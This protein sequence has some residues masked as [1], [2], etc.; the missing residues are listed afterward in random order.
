MK[1]V[2]LL[3]NTTAVMHFLFTQTRRQY[4]F[5]NTFIVTAYLWPCK[6]HTSQFRSWEAVGGSNKLYRLSMCKTA[7]KHLLHRVVVLC[8]GQGPIGL[9]VQFITWP[10]LLWWVSE[11][12]AHPLHPTPPH[13]QSLKNLLK[14][15]KS[16]WTRKSLF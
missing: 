13:F 15:R 6:M 3:D 8:Y 14:P 7:C 1:F 10:W 9:L 2:L 16:K 4:M 12:T 11:P 5:W